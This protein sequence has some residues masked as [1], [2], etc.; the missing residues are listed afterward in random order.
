MIVSWN[1]LTQYVRL[2]MP[3]E[4]LADRLALTGLNHE[5]TEDV[6]GDLAIDLEVTSNRPDCLGHLGV[7]RE[8]SVVFDKALRIPDPQAERIGRLRS[9]RSPRSRSKPP[10]FARNSP[11]GWSRA[12]RSARARGGC[13]RGWRRIGVRPISNVVDITNYVMFECGQPLHA[14]DLDTPVGPQVDRRGVPG[15]ARSWS[16]ST[17][18]PTT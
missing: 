14:Y 15:P 11:P 8:I 16:P 9:N 7:A 1:W 10:T 6:G 13:A 17:T 4:I 5:S 3:V 2:D 18:R 12:R